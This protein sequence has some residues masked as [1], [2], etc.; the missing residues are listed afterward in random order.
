MVVNSVAYAADYELLH[1]ALDLTR[2]RVVLLVAA[3]LAHR[4]LD[5]LATLGHQQ[6]LP[7]APIEGRRYLPLIVDTPYY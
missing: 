4:H 1:S 2:C 7:A 3:E 5:S 6:P